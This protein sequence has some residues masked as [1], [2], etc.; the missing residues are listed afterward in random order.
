MKF[1]V[2][3]WQLIKSNHQASSLQS[4]H[5][6]SQILFV[7]LWNE[8]L[9]STHP[10][11]SFKNRT[12]MAATKQHGQIIPNSIN[13]QNHPEFSCK[14]KC[15]LSKESNNVGELA[16]EQSLISPITSWK[17][18]LAALQLGNKDW[19]T[20]SCSS[21]TWARIICNSVVEFSGVW[22]ILRVAGSDNTECF[23]LSH[24]KFILP[25]EGHPLLKHIRYRGGLTYSKGC[26]E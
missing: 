18:T 8:V 23:S 15:Y 5:F 11:F 21:P 2:R 12:G 25:K 17:K 6:F 16:L 10:L 19:K 13:S 20:I 1:E 14:L 7:Y 22:R 3:A 4:K 9:E 26:F 24:Y